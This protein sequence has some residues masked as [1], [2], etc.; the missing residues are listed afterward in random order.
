M[1]PAAARVRA[2]RGWRALGVALLL[3]TAAAAALPPLYLLP[4][5]IVAFSGLIWLLDGAPGPW[6]A[7][8]LGWAFGLGHFLLALHWIANAFLVDSERFA[9]LIPLAVSGLAAGMALFPALAALLAWYAAGPG[10]GRVVALALSWTAAE[11]L[12]G[13]LF[14]GFPWD[15]IGYVWTVSDAMIQAYALVGVYGLGLVTVLVAGAPAALQRRRDGWMAAALLGLLALVYAGGQAR[16]AAATGA[17]VPGIALRLVQANIP[18]RE[19]WRR[20]R[21]SANLVRHL[22]LSRGPAAVAPTHVIWPE[23]ATPFFLANDSERRRL[24]GGAAPAG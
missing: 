10:W 4:L 22:E 8:A 17:D 23:T 11:W 24:L 3:G 16:L 18:Q 12:R 14:T 20:E 1:A 5:L 19:K 7:F 13:H 9:Y 15:L 6:R 21:L 2:L